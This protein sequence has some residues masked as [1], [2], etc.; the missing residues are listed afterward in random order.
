MINS[1]HGC[2]LGRFYV[3]DETRTS[4]YNLVYFYNRQETVGEINQRLYC[5]ANTTS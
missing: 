2:I 4:F 3:D 1:T 5:V